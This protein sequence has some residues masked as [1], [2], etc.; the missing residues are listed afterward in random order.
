MGFLYN[1]INEVVSPIFSKNVGD[2][3]ILNKKTLYDF[4]FIKFKSKIAS[5][6]II[7]R[8]LNKLVNSLLYFNFLEENKKL[9]L[10][11]LYFV[12]ICSSL[13]F[14]T[15]TVG[16]CVNLSAKYKTFLK[17]KLLKEKHLQH[18]KLRF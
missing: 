17:H 15:R 11:K 3:L 13:S 2:W 10:S 16:F 4:N 5:K 14:F 6:E 9:F 8:D 7:D 12:Q 18:P 1:I